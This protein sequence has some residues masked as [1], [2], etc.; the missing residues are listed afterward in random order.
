MT[1]NELDLD[2]DLDCLSKLWL[3]CQCDLSTSKSASNDCGITVITIPPNKLGPGVQ[4]PPG[5]V[6]YSITSTSCSLFLAFYLNS[7]GDNGQRL[8]RRMWTFT[9]LHSRIY[10]SH[11]EKSISPTG[12]WL[13]TL[14]GGQIKYELSC[15]LGWTLYKKHLQ[16]KS[17][18]CSQ[19]QS[20]R[21]HP[22]CQWTN[23][24]GDSFPPVTEYWMHSLVFDVIL[25]FDVLAV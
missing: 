25:V 1:T 19:P 15:L 7:V 6:R 8:P 24:A 20:V 9:H 14:T 18:I 5:S 21:E 12:W 22:L 23:C 13:V 11:A 4:C 17:F 10:Q 3:R 16:I 2:T